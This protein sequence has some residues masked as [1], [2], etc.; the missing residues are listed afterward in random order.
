MAVTK[1]M[2]GAGVSITVGG[3]TVGQLKTVQMGSAKWSTDDITNVASPTS[4]SGVIKEIIPSILDY[5]ECSL[6]GIWLYND[7]GQLALQ[8]AFNTGASVACVVTLL[9]GEGQT[10]TG[11]SLSFSGY[12]TDPPFPQ[13]SFDKAV[14]FKSI[15]KISGTVTIAYGS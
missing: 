15:I 4:G 13:I 10:T 14:T 12:V 11:T 9:K 1:S 8:T 2:T 7:A 3:A 5:G 6:D